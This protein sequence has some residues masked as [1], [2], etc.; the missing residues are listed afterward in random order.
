L[1]GKLK[2]F[3]FKTRQRGF[4]QGNGKTK[5]DAKKNLA[6]NGDEEK[7]ATLGRDGM[8]G[9][10]NFNRIKGIRSSQQQKEKG[11]NVDSHGRRK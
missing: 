9:C 1:G 3:T 6:V 7:I 5:K 2:T 11:I 4:K 10:K 8:K